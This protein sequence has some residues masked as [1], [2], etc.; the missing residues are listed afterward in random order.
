MRGLYVLEV[1]RLAA[2]LDNIKGFYIDQFYE[3]ERN[4]FR[5]KLSRRGEKKNLQI[6]LPYT[7][8]SAEIIEVKENATN[9]SMAVRK[10]ACSS[11]IT[12]VEQLSNDR[13]IMIKLERAASPINIILEMFGK[14][15]LIITDS[16]M[17]ILLTYIVHDFKDRSVRP[18]KQYKAPTN[19]SINVRNESETKGLYGEI[20]GAKGQQT[21]LA[22]MNKRASMGPMY[23]EEALARVSIN[24]DTK[25]E[26]I[27]RKDYDSIME[28]TRSIAKKCIENP[29]FLIYYKNGSILNFSLCEIS[30]YASNECKELNSLEE[31]L[32]IIYRDVGERAEEPDEEEERILSSMEKQ[33][34]LID[35]TASQIG[36]YKASGDY[37]MNNMHELNEIINAVRSNKNATAEQ[38]QKLSKRIE[39]LSIN[40]KNK[41][42]RIKPKNSVE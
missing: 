17:S 1:A 2:E 26:S 12:G 41:S 19:T 16:S 22:F 31:C 32:D 4:R 10:R 42:I 15:N 7:I 11:K 20:E 39:I 13:I 8:N 25:I 5:L 18:G 9:F 21:V 34:R 37:I 3:I 29:K 36:E 30:K 35:E 28:S 40:M 6:I 33:K 27:S 24:P 23:T 14:G 38:L